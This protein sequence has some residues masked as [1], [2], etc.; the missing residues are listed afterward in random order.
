MGRRRNPRAACGFFWLGG[1][2]SDMSGTKA[3]AIAAHAARQRPAMLALRLFRPWPIRRGP[4]TDG[5]ISDWLAEAVQAFT[6]LAGGRRI[7]IGSSMGGWL[8]LLLLRRLLRH[9][10]RCRPAHKRACPAGAGRS[11]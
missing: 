3:E 10:P 7:V 5:T 2:K 4:R 11:T 8:A 1:F 9:R 6:T